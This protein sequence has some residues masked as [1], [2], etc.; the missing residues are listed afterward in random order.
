MMSEPTGGSSGDGDSDVVDMFK[1]PE[2]YTA[3]EKPATTST[4]T[5]KNGQVLSLRFVGHSPLWV[6]K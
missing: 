5:L 1:E 4:Y 6:R 3:P 2:G